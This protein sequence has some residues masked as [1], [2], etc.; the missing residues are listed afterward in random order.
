MLKDFSRRLSNGWPESIILRKLLSF[1]HFKKSMSRNTGQLFADYHQPVVM[2]GHLSRNLF[3]SQSSSISRITYK[4]YTRGLYAWSHI[5][6]L[7]LKIR[8]HPT[9]RWS[10]RSGSQWNMERRNRNDFSWRKNRFKLF[11]F[12]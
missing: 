3:S 1:P 9:E 12:R 6:A 7:N 2:V 11:N 8:V 10:L 4:S 5:V